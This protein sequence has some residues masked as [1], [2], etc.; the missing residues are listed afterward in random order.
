MN[1][2][3]NISMGSRRIRA[4]KAS[5]SMMNW[6][7]ASRLWQSASSIISTWAISS[8]SSSR[9]ELAFR[10]A[11]RKLIASDGSGAWFVRYR[12]GVGEDGTGLWKVRGPLQVLHIKIELGWSTVY[13]IKLWILPHQRDDATYRRIEVAH[14]AT[15]CFR[16][17]ECCRSS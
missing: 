5:C 11:L 1:I 6:L 7:N 4:S 13:T 15:I 2:L 9:S 3:V 8:S 17:P 12:W 16:N 10:I 14:L